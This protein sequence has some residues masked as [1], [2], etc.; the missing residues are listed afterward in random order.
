MLKPSE[1]VLQL[2]RLGLRGDTDAVRQFLRRVMR[3]AAHDPTASELRVELGKLLVVS[4]PTPRGMRAATNTAGTAGTPVDAGTFQ[5]LLKIEHHVTAESPLLESAVAMEF[6][7]IMD[8]HR[9]AAELR[10]AGVEPT[11][12]ILLVGPPGV[13]KTM[14]ARHLAAQLQLPLYSLDLAAVISSY[15]GRTGQNLRSVLDYARAHPCVLL[16]DEF[17]ALAKR[18]DDPSDVGELKRIVNVLLLEI[19]SWPATG[20]LIAATNHPEILDRAVERRFQRV[21]SMPLPSESVRHL[22][23]R[24][25]FADAN[26]TL[27]ES[28]LALAAAATDGDSGSSLERLAMDTIR[29]AIMRRDLD[30][31]Q[32]LLQPFRERL[33]ALARGR[34]R[35]PR[36]VNAV[37]RLHGVDGV[38]LRELAD[39]LG[40]SHMTIARLIRVRRPLSEVRAEGPIRSVAAAAVELESDTTA[41]QRTRRGATTE[42]TA[43]KGAARDA[44]NSKRRARDTTKPTTKTRPSAKGT[45]PAARKPPKRSGADT[46]R[47]SSP[48]APRRARPR[49]A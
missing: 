40:V 17:D 29:H 37:A 35:D 36:V 21:I 42:K 45:A 6:A 16:L 4:E 46:A 47:S 38:P 23:L 32:L 11:R 27:S 10:A 43:V 26:L 15:L 14:S 33:A 9:R 25:A 20:L 18:R 5:S 7:M 34:H 13:G 19:E 3:L 44:G 30:P 22:L 2:A 49:S 31:S 48:L 24:R 28:A 1:L 8:E 12:S 39:L 41:P